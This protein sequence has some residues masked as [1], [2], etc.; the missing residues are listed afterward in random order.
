MMAKIDMMESYGG[1]A[2]GL[3]LLLKVSDTVSWP[4]P[5]EKKQH[6]HATNR[7]VKL[8]I[9]T[10]PIWIPVERFDN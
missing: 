10:E 2:H 5:L 7:T 1:A 3:M 6:V 8:P 9:S 4:R